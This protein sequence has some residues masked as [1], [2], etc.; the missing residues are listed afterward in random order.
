MEQEIWKDITDYEGMY[1]VSNFGNVRSLDRIVLASDGRKIRY[2]GKFLK[3]NKNSTGYFC[4]TLY[5]RPIIK[6]KTFTI[7]TLVAQSF[8]GHKNNKTQK[9]VINHIDNNPLNNHVS[10][11]EI[12]TNRY[13]TS[14]HN[15]NKT[16]FTGVR[17]SGKKYIAQIRIK[18]KNEENKISVGTSEKSEIAYEYYKLAI[19]N[20]KELKSFSTEHRLEFR[21]YIKQLYITSQT[22]STSSFQ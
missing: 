18:I 11:L 10:N 14:C 6:H 12:V 21:N 20:E 1:Q 13:N 4:A 15:K 16:G 22:K 3:I 19:I 5:K 7:H 9:L 8:L 2:K 17:K